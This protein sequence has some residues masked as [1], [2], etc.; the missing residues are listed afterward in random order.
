M[1]PAAPLLQR[2]RSE[3]LGTRLSLVEEGTYE[4]DHIMPKRAGTRSTWC[5]TWGRDGK[6]HL[7]SSKPTL[8]HHAAGRRILADL[9]AH[10]ASRWK[11][12]PYAIGRFML[13]TINV[14][15]LAIYFW[16][17]ARLVER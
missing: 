1:A 11:E 17:L 9:P 16:L 12:H 14:L 8:A 3:P 15:P 13:V 6:P 10:G 5:G 4:I 2:Q 7:Y